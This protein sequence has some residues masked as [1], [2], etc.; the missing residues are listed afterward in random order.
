MPFFG[1]TVMRRITANRVTAVSTYG[2]GKL[3]FIKIINI[4]QNTAVLVWRPWLSVPYSPLS[5]CRENSETCEQIFFFHF[6]LN[7][8][9]IPAHKRAHTV[10]TACGCV[11]SM[12]LYFIVRILWYISAQ[13]LWQFVFSSCFNEMVNLTIHLVARFSNELY[14]VSEVP[15]ITTNT[16]PNGLRPAH[17][18]PNEDSTSVYDGIKPHQ[19]LTWGGGERET[20]KWSLW[21]RKMKKM[22]DRG[23][24]RSTV[25]LTRSTPHS[26]KHASWLKPTYQTI[27]KATFFTMT[28]E[29][30]QKKKKKDNINTQQKPIK[31]TTTK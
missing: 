8:Y 3:Y 29:H 7:I 25:S 24:D 6:S 19:R 20:Q 2:R 4:Q 13:L 18:S 23:D 5:Y 21:F 14:L 9:I 12:V 27:T 1:N 16:R 31:T 10:S 17:W 11:Y 28:T 26:L 30:G 15:P 22:D